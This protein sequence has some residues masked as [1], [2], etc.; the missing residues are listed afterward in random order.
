MSEWLKAFITECQWTNF[1]WI[2]YL[3]VSDSQFSSCITRI[4]E[5]DWE[6]GQIYES[7][8]YELIGM[9][10]PFYIGFHKSVFKFFFVNGYPITPPKTPKNYSRIDIDLLSMYWQ[11]LCKY[12]IIY[13]NDLP[14][15]YNQKNVKLKILTNIL[16]WYKD[17]SW[18]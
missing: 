3:F 4:S 5:K 10:L 13:I 12:H 9:S 6:S 15:N 11:F 14:Q 17:F 16:F 2:L 7:M 18:F 8:F 1:M